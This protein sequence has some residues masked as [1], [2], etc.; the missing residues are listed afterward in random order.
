MTIIRRRS[1]FGVPM[2]LTLALAA[3][4]G[5]SD[6]S[7]VVARAGPYAITKAMFAHALYTTGKETAGGIPVPPEFTACIARLKAVDARSVSSGAKPPSVATL[8]S[9]CRSHYQGLETDAMDELII[10]DWAM[11]GAAEEGVSVSNQEVQQ[12]LKEQEGKEPA[13]FAKTLAAS[14]RTVADYALSLRV[15]L[16]EEGIRRVI[17]EKSEHPSQAQVAS[18]YDEHRTLFGTPERRDLEI[19]RAG[20]EAGAQTVK[21]EIASGKSFASVVKKLPLQQPIYSKEGLVLGY[22][23]NMYSEPPLNNAIL[24]AKPHVLSGPINIFLGSYIFEVTRIYPARPEPLAQ[25]QAAI[26]KSLP[27]ELYEQK[28]VAFISGWRTRW[29]AKT[30]CLPGYVFAKCRQFKPP[31]GSPPQAADPFTFN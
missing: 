10:D 27:N 31:A 29:M 28:L 9:E 15:Q 20:S 6:P 26:R 12:L 21:R 25:A 1:A 30:D 22:E 7:A 24:A 19:A 8:R 11:G 13:Q 5:S 17:R 2:L 16:L 23:S 3:C 4:G 14:G 18:Y